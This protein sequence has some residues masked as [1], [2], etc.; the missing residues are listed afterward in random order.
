MPHIIGQLDIASVNP[1]IL[2]C[3]I[4]IT[5]EFVDVLW[6]KPKYETS[7]IVDLDKCVLRPKQGQPSLIHKDV[8]EIRFV[9]I[10]AYV[11][12]LWFF[13]R[14]YETRAQI[15]VYSLPCKMLPFSFLQHPSRHSRRHGTVYGG[16]SIRSNIYSQSLCDLV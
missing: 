16:G 1:C 4:I 12:V 13:E 11:A 7:L 10:M 14:Q 2:Y 9:R 3:T 5:L 6:L 8:R 15:A